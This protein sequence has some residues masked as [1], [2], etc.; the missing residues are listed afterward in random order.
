MALGGYFSSSNNFHISAKGCSPDDTSAAIPRLRYHD[1]I[2]D[3]GWHHKHLCPLD[4]PV[5]GITR[6]DPTQHL[7]LCFASFRTEISRRCI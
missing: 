3:A 1:G 4:I 7:P 6:I 2:P 5:T